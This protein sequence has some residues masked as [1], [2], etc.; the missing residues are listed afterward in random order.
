MSKLKH[1]QLTSITNDLLIGAA[2]ILSI[3]GLSDFIWE[4]DQEVVDTYPDAK[5]YVRLAKIIDRARVD[6]KEI[7][8][9]FNDFQEKYASRTKEV[10]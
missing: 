10:A 7:E 4:L 9:E 1:D 2:H 3:N 6:L 8:P 5:K